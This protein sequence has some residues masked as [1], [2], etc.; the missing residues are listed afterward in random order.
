MITSP[1]TLRIEPLSELEFRDPFIPADL[2]L[3]SADVFVAERLF[4]GGRS[5][6]RAFDRDRLGIPGQTLF[7][8]SQ[9]NL[10]PAGGNGLLLANIDLRF[11]LFDALGGTIFY[12]TGNVWADW[13]DI[14]P[15][16][17]RAGA[18][19]GLRYLSPIGP[20]RFEVGW[21]IDRLPG[22]DSPAYNF[23]LGY[24]F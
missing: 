1:A 19:I 17:F 18:G 22:D 13:R 2:D 15:G 8:D 11:P 14:D 9:G 5:T 10:V 4:A 7:P 3:P 21:P 6:H 24:S 23:S 16:E 12:D 20:L